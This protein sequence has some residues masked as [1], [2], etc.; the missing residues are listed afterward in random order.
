[1]MSRIGSTVG[2]KEVSRIKKSVY[3]HTREVE[4]L[5]IALFIL[6]SL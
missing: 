5:K 2:K 3:S 4:I 6:I 1:M